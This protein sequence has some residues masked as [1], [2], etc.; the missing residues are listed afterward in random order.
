MPIDFMCEID[1][2]DA[3]F[4]DDSYLIVD[5][6]NT[7]EIESIMAMPVRTSDYDEMTRLNNCFE[8]EFKDIILCEDSNKLNKT[9]PSYVSFNSKYKSISWYGNVFS[10]NYSISYNCEPL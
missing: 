1:V 5:I 3:S 2:L 7:N 10:E 4:T 8:S 6:S 9:N